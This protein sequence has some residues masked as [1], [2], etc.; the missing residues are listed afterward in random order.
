MA[1]MG[2]KQVSSKAQCECKTPNS[3]KVENYVES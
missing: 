3:I 2:T 1:N